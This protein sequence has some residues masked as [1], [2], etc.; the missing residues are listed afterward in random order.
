MS[1]RMIDQFI[2]MVKIDSESGDEVGFIAYL[3]KEFEA[4]GGTAQLDCYGNLIA[5]FPAKGCEGKDPILFSCH[6][7]TVKP[8]KGIEPVIEDGTIRSKG[9][10]IPWIPLLSVAPHILPLTWR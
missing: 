2:E 1:Q 10:T 8:G 4:L 6:A 5:I 9:E 7:D 3:K